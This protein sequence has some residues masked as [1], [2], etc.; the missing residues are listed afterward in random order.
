MVD[1]SNNKQIDKAL[2]YIRDI[3]RRDISDKDIES[4]Y[5]DENSNSGSP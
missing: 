1:E 4:K 5:S 2:G 3:V